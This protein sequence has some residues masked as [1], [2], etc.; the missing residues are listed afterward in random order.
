MIVAAVWA[1]AAL[2]LSSWN[3]GYSGLHYK[4][5]QGFYFSK[6]AQ[7]YICGQVIVANHVRTLADYVLHIDPVQDMNKT[8][9]NMTK[10]GVNY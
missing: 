10:M 8:T 3:F 4:L 6:E 2:V 9:K 1:W 7:N 5:L